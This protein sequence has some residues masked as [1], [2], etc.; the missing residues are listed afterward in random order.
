MRKAVRR[1][2]GLVMR[3]TLAGVVVVWLTTGVSSQTSWK[4]A[5]FVAG[6]PPIIPL[7]AVSG[8]EVLVEA[9]VTDV[10]EVGDL[11][12]LRITPP[13]T[14]QVLEAVGDWRF[15][16][17]EQMV[18]KVPGDPR[19]I[20][21]EAVAS[22]VLIA[23]VFRPPALNSPTIGEPP[24]DVQRASDD[25]AVPLSTV[26]P[27]YPPLGLADG[28]VVVQVAVGV[29]GQVVNAATVRSAA[30]FDEL[31]LAAARQWTFRPARIHGR[32]EQT[33]AYLVF[34]FRRPVT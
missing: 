4:P 13:F 32:L 18:A 7:E 20:V 5:K 11:V 17:A 15:Q 34:A 30:G 16:A 29:N 3:V 22:R 33:F 25:V 14:Q 27:A 24:K 23:C 9:T 21:R 2:A 8:G 6:M 31:A 19:S 28:V 26:T 1:H 12:P 10:G